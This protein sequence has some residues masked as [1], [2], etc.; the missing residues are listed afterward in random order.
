MR[1]PRRFVTL[2]KRIRP[3]KAY[4]GLVAVC[5]RGFHTVRK[6]ISPRRAYSGLVAGCRRRFHTLRKRITP[7]R[8]IASTGLVAFCLLGLSLFAGCPDAPIAQKY[9]AKSA[10]Q[11]AQDAGAEQLVPELFR[12][13]QEAFAAGVREL[14]QQLA[15]SRFRR[16]F[17]RAEALLDAATRRA[18]LA[19]SLAAERRA[20]A[21]RE[22]ESL[23]KRAEDGFDQFEWL[24]GY[25]PPRSPVRA[26]LKRAEVTCNEAR[27]LLAAGEIERAVIAAR[28]ASA[29][30]SEA[31]ARFSRYLNA[32]TSP[33]RRRQFSRWVRDTLEWSDKS[34]EP[35]IIVDKQRRTLTLVKNGRRVRTY[36]AELGV[37]G[38]LDKIY[39]GDRATP[40]G[41]YR[42]TEKRGPRQTRW[43]KA[44]LLNY[45]NDEDLEEF[46]RMRR[47]GQI[48]KRARPG[49]LIEIHG[50]GG[51]GQDWTDGCVALV[52]P[53]MDDL[54]DRVSVGTPVTIVGYEAD[55][56]AAAE[57]SPSRIASRRD[58]GAPG[59][60]GGP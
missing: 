42:V 15:R 28:R 17:G 57:S 31:Y 2:R 11:L 36:R 12:S 41:K 29:Q 48:S 9:S 21:R 14:D 32:G 10:L 33:E 3:G 19:I 16:E 6:R 60:G 40:E 20:D 35:A 26:D 50:E 30:V 45:P 1:L 56:Y 44:L 4:S 49:G 23:L 54:F 24:G 53:D 52:N 25:V 46:D 47:R 7:R 8:A 39:A 34:G 55:P 51:R 27:A 13:S 38:T 59:S 5:L 43:Y 18:R 37:N 58:R 22:V